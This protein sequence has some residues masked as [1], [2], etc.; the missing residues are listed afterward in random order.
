MPFALLCRS[1]VS[2][3]ARDSSHGG[4]KVN[5]FLGKIVFHLLPSP[6]GRYFLNKLMTGG[7]YARDEYPV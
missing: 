1:T 4:K 7:K 2:E 6:L 3:Q 5:A